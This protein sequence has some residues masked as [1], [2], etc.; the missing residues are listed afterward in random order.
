MPQK[1]VHAGFAAAKGFEGLHGGAAAASFQDGVQVF[2]AGG[3]VGR[4]LGICAFFKGCIGVGAEYFGP[5]VAV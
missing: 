1:R 4:T 2:F 5:F 3:G